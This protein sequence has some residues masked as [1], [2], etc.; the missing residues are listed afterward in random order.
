[1]LTPAGVSRDTLINAWRHSPARKEQVAAEIA[2]TIVGGRYHYWAE[3]DTLG[4]L[5]RAYDTSQRTISAAKNLLAAQGFLVKD[6]NRYY[7]VGG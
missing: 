3:L 7:V 1:M 5:A 2:A 4:A 6:N